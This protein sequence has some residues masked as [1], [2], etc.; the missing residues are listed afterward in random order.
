MDRP[1]FSH[2]P[3]MDKDF[4]KVAE[5]PLVD[6]QRDFAVATGRP[7]QEKPKEA[8]HFRFRP[9]ELVPGGMDSPSVELVE[10]IVREE[11][12]SNAQRAIRDAHHRHEAEAK[13]LQEY[14]DNLELSPVTREMEGRVEA[15][16]FQLKKE[17]EQE[18]RDVAAHE[19]PELDFENDSELK[20]SDLDLE[21]EKE[22]DFDRRMQERNISR[23]FNRDFER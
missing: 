10:D 18:T 11:L 6:A 15:E 19:V 2:A 12:D 8:P 21:A 13:E 23:S 1:H 9:P 16:E 3:D 4:A 7:A 5:K 22:Q 20:V 17:F 14:R